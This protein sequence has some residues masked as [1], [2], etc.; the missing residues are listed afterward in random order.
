M[1]ANPETRYHCDRCGAD[2]VMPVTNAPPHA[3]MAGPIEWTMLRI[4]D[5]PSSPPRHLCGNCSNLFIA[6]M[7]EDYG[8]QGGRT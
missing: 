1:T 3:R 4:G 5:D 2:A 6:F 8:Q 7:G